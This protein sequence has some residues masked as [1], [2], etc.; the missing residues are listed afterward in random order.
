[1]VTPIAN[2]AFPSVLLGK[3]E[4]RVLPRRMRA[5]HMPRPGICLYDEALMQ[6]G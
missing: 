2:P 6:C 4:F 3:R 1:M 5:K